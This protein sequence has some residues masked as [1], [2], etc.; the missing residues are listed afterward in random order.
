MTNDTKTT[1]NGAAPE[2]ANLLIEGY[3]DWNRLVGQ[4]ERAA[5]DTADLLADPLATE[6]LLADAPILRAYLLDNPRADHR[7]AALAC[8][9]QC[10]DA[11]KRTDVVAAVEAVKTRNA[12]VR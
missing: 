5:S 4:Y 11:R 8:R 10:R 3:A 2:R 12:E 9:G 6:W 7:Q 1:G